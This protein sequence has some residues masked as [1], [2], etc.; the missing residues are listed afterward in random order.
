MT[1]PTTSLRICPLCEAT[2]GLTIVH[3]A[4]RVI[5]VRGD[6]ADVFSRG[7]LCPKGASLGE[8]NDDPDRLDAPLVRRDGELVEVGWDEAFA[9]VARGLGAVQAAHGRDAVAL[10]VG[11]PLVHTL[12]I[13]LYFAPLREA[14]ET[15]NVYTSASLDTMPKSVACG[16]MYGDPLAIPVPD[17]DRTDLLVI[18]GANPFESN[19]SLWTAPDI[20]GRIRKLRKRGGRLVVVDPARTRTAAAADRHLRITPGADPYLLAGILHVLFAEDLVAPVSPDL[21]DGLDAVRAIAE[22]FPP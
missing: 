4:D 16:L 15:R 10:Y 17:I 6:E 21:F 13:S 7:Y 5:A 2:C 18:L 1:D 11:N 12:G 14:L 20:P 22:R 9:E 19:G 3:E 8:F